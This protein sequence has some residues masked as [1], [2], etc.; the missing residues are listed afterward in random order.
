[1]KIGDGLHGPRKTSIPRS[2]LACC[3]RPTT[4]LAC[5]SSPAVLPS[6]PRPSRRAR[7]G[8]DCWTF[9]SC[10]FSFFLSFSFSNFSSS[11]L[12]LTC[13]SLTSFYF[14]CY[15]HYL[16][17]TYRIWAPP[18]LHCC[19]FSVF[20]SSISTMMVSCS[21]SPHWQL[22]VKGTNESSNI[23]SKIGKANEWTFV[24]HV[25]TAMCMLYKSYTWLCG[26]RIPHCGRCTSKGSTVRQHATLTVVQYCMCSI[27]QTSCWWQ[28]IIFPAC[29][30]GVTVQCSNW[31][32]FSV[33]V[34][35]MYK[36]CACM[37]V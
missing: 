14:C 2:W 33:L 3:S 35:K 25:R 11:Q 18:L 22:G 17:Y 5:V 15:I 21:I 28:C 4:Y 20:V 34:S 23:C 29:C 31:C 12:P 16:P 19:A 27:E 7:W 26:Y 13:T 32:E 24:I 8:P 9:F 10:S 1:M 36:V 30:T 37:I 6:L